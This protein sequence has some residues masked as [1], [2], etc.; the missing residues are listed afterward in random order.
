MLRLILDSTFSVS[1]IF[2]FDEVFCLFLRTFLFREVFVKVG[3]LTG[4]SSIF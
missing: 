1:F 2:C 4:G 3:G